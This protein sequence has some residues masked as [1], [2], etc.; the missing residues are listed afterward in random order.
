MLISA[1]VKT[2]ARAGAAA[3]LALALA[4]CMTTGYP[5]QPAPPSGPPPVAQ[6]VDPEA[7]RQ[8]YLARLDAAHRQPGELDRGFFALLASFPADSEEHRLFYDALPQL[9]WY[10]SAPARDWVKAGHPRYYADF[11]KANTVA[12]FVQVRGDR[13][14]GRYIADYMYDHAPE[15]V[16]LARKPRHADVVIEL[17]LIDVASGFQVTARKQKQKKYKKS[18]RHHPDLS[19]RKSRAIYTRVYE[20]AVIDYDVRVTAHAHGR[21]YYRDRWY[22][23]VVKRFEWGENLRAVT[24]AGIKPT[25]RFP[26]DGVYRAFHRN[27]DEYR[28]QVMAEV[29]DRFGARMARSVAGLDYPLLGDLYPDRRAFYRPYARP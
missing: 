7:L 18:V 5:S 22:D 14:L 15:H 27:T 25:T 29:T 10:R 26:S 4:G 16:A 17:D 9:D 28:A 1:P 13:D 20:R 2:L 24:P 23:D 8:A 6:P 11:L 3:G 21:I 12:V 19:Q